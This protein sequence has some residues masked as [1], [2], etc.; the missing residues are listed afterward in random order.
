[1]KLTD[2]W[3]VKQSPTISFELFPAKTEKGAASLEK[4][5]DILAALKPD[6]VSVTF[7]AGGSTRGGSRQLVHKLKHDKGLEVLAY[8][9]CYGLGPEE[10]TAVLDSYHE[11]GVEN[12]LAV[13]GDTPREEGFE[14]HPDSLPHASDLVSF[15]RPRFDFCLGVAGYPEGHIEASSADKDLEYLKLKVDQGAEYIVTNYTYDNSYF[16]NFLDRCRSAGIE[17]PIL[18]GVMPIYSIKM[19]KMLAGMCGATIPDELRTGIAALDVDD[20][21]ALLSFG[22]EYA[23][24]QCTELLE[25]GVPGIHFYTMDRSHSTESIV[26]SLRSEGHL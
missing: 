19:M 11:I 2:I 14:P 9:A 20:K 18:P 10:I 21:G 17:V 26:K 12:I 6:F 23:L 16:F 15:I 25:K 3:H 8:F 1:M 4:T 22:I 7:G 5:I 24:N 13:R